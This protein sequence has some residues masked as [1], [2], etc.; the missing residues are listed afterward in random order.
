MNFAEKYC[1]ISE[2]DKPDN[3]TKKIISDDAYAL[4]EIIQTLIGEIERA[5]IR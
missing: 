4:G 1:S 2:K 5:R 3:K